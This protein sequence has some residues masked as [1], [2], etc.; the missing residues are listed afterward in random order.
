MEAGPWRKDLSGVLF[1]TLRCLITMEY[2]KH[3][4]N[5]IQKNCTL[6]ALLY[7]KK[8]FHLNNLSF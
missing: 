5:E 4:Y 6:Y 8:S 1:R 2:N 7:N 3:K